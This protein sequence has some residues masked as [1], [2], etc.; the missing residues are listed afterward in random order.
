MQHRYILALD[1]GTS[2]TKAALW[3]DDG[4]LVAQTT[5]DY[6]L[7]RPYVSWAEIDAL[8]WWRAVCLTT[9]QVLAQSGVAGDQVVGIG[10]DGLGW[11]LV[12]VDRRGD[13]LFPAMTWLDRRAEAEADWLRSLPEA[14]DLVNLV[15]NPLDASY[16]TPKLLWLQRQRPRI[17]EATDQ[18]LTSTGFIV[19]RLTGE[20]S[21]D[22]TQAYGYHFFD[23]RR[24]RWDEEAARL[25]GMPLEKL[26]PLFP[27]ISVAGQVTEV[28]AAAMGLAAGT[29]VIVGGLDASVGS[30]GAGVVRLGQTVDQGGQ[31]GGM[32]LSVDHVI[33]EPQLI[34]SHHI[35]PGQY[36]FQSGTVGGGS[37]S[38]FRD[39]LGHPEVN[40]AELLHSTPFDLMSSQVELTPAGSHGL[41]FLPYMA[42]ERTPLWN[43]NARGVFFGLSYKTTRSDILRAIMEG[44]AFAVYH[45]LMIAERNGVTVKEWIGVGGGTRSAVWCQIKADVTGKPYVLARRRGGGEGG[46]ALGLYAMVSHAIGECDDLADR[47][48]AL[49][50]ERRAFEPSPASHAMYEDLFSIYRELSDKLLGDFDR[51]AAVVEKHERFLAP[52]ACVD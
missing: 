6:S 12:P 18:F 51:L 16:I 45:N 11:T 49:L 46:H 39:V 10:V 7:Q 20:N 13:P 14:S 5:E 43:S 34:F 1:I 32:A 8:E 23:I 36:L 30:T 15:A 52:G 9:Q 40:A 27:A 3:T 24:E 31:A 47:I 19:R 17:F 35:L 22:F 42:G 2:S 28:A 33:V 37:P 29:P 26:P 4:T 41:I 50:P 25:I 21:C 38:W 44:C 48:E